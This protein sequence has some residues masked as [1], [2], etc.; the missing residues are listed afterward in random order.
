MTNLTLC[1]AVNYA[2]PSNPSF[3]ITS[4]EAYYENYTQ[5]YFKN[6]ERALAQIPC[7]TT[8]SA[9]YSLATNCTSCTQ[10]YKEWFCAVSIPRCTDFGS[11]GAHLQS[12]NMFQ[13]F[14]NGTSLQTLDPALYNSGIQAAGTNASRNPDIDA[15]VQPGPYKEI[16][17]CD[18]LCYNV[19]RNCPAKLEFG[20]PRPGYKGFD[21]SYRERFPSASPEDQATTTPITCNYPGAIKRNEGLR[22][23]PHGVL[24]VSVLVGLGMMFI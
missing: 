19:V 20:C 3:N 9:Q 1:D 12:R 4:L 10:A 6:F 11:T 24:G 2:V 21:T 15:T 8:S 17:P 13:P 23:L 18:D 14:P 5:F 22:R 16:L 7:N